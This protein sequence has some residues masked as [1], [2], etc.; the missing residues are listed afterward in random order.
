MWTLCGGEKRQAGGLD[1]SVG[2]EGR[3]TSS[4]LFVCACACFL[5]LRVQKEDEGEER[6][7]CGFRGRVTHDVAYTGKPSA[8]GL[9]PSTSSYL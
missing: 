2:L 9:N 3:E 7:V 4:C 1:L 8:S 6:E 5:S